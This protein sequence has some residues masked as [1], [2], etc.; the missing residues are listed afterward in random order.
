MNGRARALL[1]AAAIHAD[2]LIGVLPDTRRRRRWP[3]TSGYARA[4]VLVVFL[5]DA[6]PRRRWPPT[7][8]CVRALVLVGL[9]LGLVLG[10]A[11]ATDPGTL[12]HPAPMIPAAVMPRMAA[13]QPAESPV[14]VP[15][16][17]P[18]QA[19]PPAGRVPG[20]ATGV[21]GPAR[22]APPAAQ[23]AE[24]TDTVDAARR[25]QLAAVHRLATGEGQ[26]VAVI[27]TG[28]FAHERFGGRLHGVADFLAGGD[29]STDCDGHGTAVAGL[30]AAAPSRDDDVVGMAPAATVL[31]IRQASSVFTKPDTNGTQRPAGDVDTLAEAVV[32]AVQ[33]RATVINI[34]EAA[35]LSPARAAREG[36]L[37][38]SALRFAARS[39]VVVV[40]A[41]GNA[42]VGGCTGARDMHE[43]SLPG[44]YNDDV[45][46]VGATG[47]DDT[48]APF[49]VPG[50]WV[51]VAAAGTGLWSLAV[52][53]GVTSDGVA[54]TSFAAP[55][56]AGLAALVRQRFPTLT[57][58]Q[59]TDRILATA[60]RPAGGRDP[61]LGHGVIDPL[62]AL[63]AEPA[64]LRAGIE[65]TPPAA[66]LAGTSPS[67][68]SPGERLPTE[69]LAATVLVGA[70]TAGVTALRRTH[71]TRRP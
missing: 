71:R 29:G 22:C 17:P 57:A 32:L 46:T 8:G 42:G 35:C 39:D 62:A 24:T 21:R 27:D 2:V 18:I 4:L 45:L 14:P 47:P 48:A 36:A 43:V 65:P 23:T 31:T 37:L 40:A 56:V 52:G 30:L 6:G 9:L 58:T 12:A 16:P 25:L 3:P 67:S 26:V 28:V 53:G 19:A 34:S 59:V 70:A 15:G 51:D 20:P 1:R 54:G 68:T 55:R 33:R 41:A 66:V 44:W 38:Q 64:V 11:T 7:S 50:S 10:P 60:R 49:T 63:T 13:A 5:P 69:L 61:Y